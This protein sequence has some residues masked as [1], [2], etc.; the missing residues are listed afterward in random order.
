HYRWWYAPDQRSAGER[1][2]RGMRPNAADV[3]VQAVGE[4]IRDRMVNR[5]SLVGSSPQTREQIEASFKRL[6]D[7]LERHLSSRPYLFG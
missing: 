6:L 7:I 3:E 2:A 1:L 5:L 4:M